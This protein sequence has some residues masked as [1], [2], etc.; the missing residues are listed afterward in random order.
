MNN[1]WSLDIP[2]YYTK[3]SVFPPSDDVELLQEFGYGNRYFP[4]RCVE[5]LEVLISCYL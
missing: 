2:N 3:G 1:I 5:K 4:T